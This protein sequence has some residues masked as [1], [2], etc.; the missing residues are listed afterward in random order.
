MTV[1]DYK[2]QALVHK[3]ILQTNGGTIWTLF[4]IPGDYVQERDFIISFE[5]DVSL[6]CIY[7]ARMGKV[8]SQVTIGIK[9]KLYFF[10]FWPL[11]FDGNLSS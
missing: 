2:L 6:S 5:K 9:E 10:F 8:S 1:S 7:P 4:I 3:G 11:S